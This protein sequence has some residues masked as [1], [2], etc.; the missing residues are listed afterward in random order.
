MSTLNTLMR[1]E[2]EKKMK[3]R[4]LVNPLISVLLSVSSALEFYGFYLTDFRLFTLPLH[5]FLGFLATFGLVRRRAW[6]R[7]LFYLLYLPQVVQGGVLLWSLILMESFCFSTLEGLL[8][9]GLVVYLVLLTLS[10]LLLLS[11]RGVQR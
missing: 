4:S 11:G 3:S 1:S 6:G 9:V 10:L 8:E 2:E 5:G 7:W